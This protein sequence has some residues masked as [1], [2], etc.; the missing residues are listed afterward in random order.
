MQVFLETITDFKLMK[1]WYIYPLLS[2]F[3]VAMASIAYFGYYRAPDGTTESTDSKIA[4]V[5]IPSNDYTKNDPNNESVEEKKPSPSEKSPGQK[6]AKSIYS[7]GNSL[8]FG[9]GSGG[10]DYTDRL[11][12]LLGSN[13]SVEN[14]GIAGNTTAQML[15]RVDSKSD[16]TIVW[17]GINDVYRGIPT[18]TTTENL[19]NIYDTVHKL[20]GKEI[21]LNITPS[22]G[23][24]NWSTEKQDATEY[25]NDWIFSSSADYKIDVYTAVEDPNSPGRILPLYDAGDHLHL[26]QDGYYAVADRIYNLLKEIESL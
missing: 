2:I 17:G 16:Y 19:A 23:D 10:D 24:P 12:S 15:A 6:S 25:L 9:T 8:T 5:E 14:H 18:S 13:W 3:V 21:A 7:L 1:Y 11:I 20:K 26:Q 22:K 4:S